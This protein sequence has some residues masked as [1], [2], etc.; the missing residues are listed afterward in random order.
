MI[1]NKRKA[2]LCM[3][4]AIST[5]LAMLPILHSTEIVKAQDTQPTMTGMDVPTVASQLE[6]TVESTLQPVTETPSEPTATFTLESSP[7]IDN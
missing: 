2:I 1:K 5:L 6:L 7:H 4:L 3:V